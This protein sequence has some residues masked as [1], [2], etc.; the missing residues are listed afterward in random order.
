MPEK[1]IVSIGCFCT[2]LKEG[3]CYLRRYTGYC[4]ALNNCDFND[5]MCHFR[6]KKYGGP[7]M[8]DLWRKERAQL[9]QDT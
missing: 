3:E 8:Y 1:D 9:C 6:K 7:N 2:H 5:G 4:M